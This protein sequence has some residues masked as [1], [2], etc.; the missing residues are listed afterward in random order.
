MTDK[1]IEKYNELHV[2]VA[3]FLQ[4]EKVEPEK[5]I[6]DLKVKNKELSD[7]LENPEVPKE[8]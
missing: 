2:V 7:A 1:I 5:F 6:E 8:E 4:K 3:D